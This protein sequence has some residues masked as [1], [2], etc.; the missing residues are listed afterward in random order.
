VGEG[1]AAENACKLLEGG[2]GAELAR[3]E[4][5]KVLGVVLVQTADRSL[6]SSRRHLQPH[7]WQT[8]QAVLAPS[9]TTN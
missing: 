7:I 6:I 4:E 3:C 9:A 5:P 1:S 2:K 8:W